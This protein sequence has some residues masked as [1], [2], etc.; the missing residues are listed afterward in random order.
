M[1]TIEYADFGDDALG[2]WAEGEA[3]RHGFRP[4]VGVKDLNALP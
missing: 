2:R 1:F 4:Y 3:A